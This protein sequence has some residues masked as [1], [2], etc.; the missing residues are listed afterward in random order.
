MSNII[1]SQLGDTYHPTHPGAKT[2]EQLP[3]G[4]FMIEACDG[5][6]E[7]FHL[8][9]VDDLGA[10]GKLYGNIE[11]TATRA[12]SSFM[13]RPEITTGVFL[14]GIRGGGK[15]LTAKRISQIA[16]EKHKIPTLLLDRP[17]GTI[18]FL[19]FMNAIRQP[20]VVFADEFEKTHAV[21]STSDG[22]TVHDPINSM[23]T[24][25]DGCQSTHK[26]FIVAVNNTDNNLRVLLNR[27]GRFHYRYLFNRLTDEVVREYSR[28]TLKNPEH[29]EGL[30]AVMNL[31]AVCSFDVLKAI[32]WEMNHYGESADV[33]VDNLNITVNDNRSVSGFAKLK[34]AETDKKSIRVHGYYSAITGNCSLYTDPDTQEPKEDALGN[35]LAGFSPRLR[36]SSMPFCQLDKKSLVRCDYEAGEYEFEN[37]KVHVFLVDDSIRHERETQDAA[38]QSLVI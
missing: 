10:P 25:L 28:D 6:Q 32:I 24:M 5:K 35:P 19:K 20:V 11:K 7:S 14:E 34:S 31:V 33:A 16:R 26:L 23:L 38:K 3:P 1:F 4:T 29:I 27:P 9:A 2:H 8:R 21:V 37:D 30:V 13:A 36:N 18:G 17:Y 15:T 22:E 12:V